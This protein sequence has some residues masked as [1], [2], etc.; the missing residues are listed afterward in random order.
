MELSLGFTD[1]EITPWGGMAVVKRMLDHIG[2]DAALHAAELPQPGSNRGYAPEQLVNQFMLSVWSGANRFEH[3]EVTRFDATLG[4][5]F[6]YEKMANY[7]ALTRLLDK[8]DQATIESVFP[9]LY[10]HLFDQVGLQTLTLD[11]DSTVLTRYGFQQG[12]IRGYN[13]SKRGR[14]SHHPLMAFVADS[15]ML[16]NVWLRPGNAH[17]ANNAIA[18]L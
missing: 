10:Q 14:A 9:G 3:L 6:G 5:I 16:A 13:P 15:R 17:T 8:F 4:K 18:F 7:K 11:L 1:K 12:A 2:W